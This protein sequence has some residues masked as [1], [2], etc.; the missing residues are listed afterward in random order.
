[1]SLLRQAQE[2]QQQ[3]INMLIKPRRFIKL[4]KH[5]TKNSTFPMAYL[6]WKGN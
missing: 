4:E 3:P 6:L 1:M 5:D 2:N